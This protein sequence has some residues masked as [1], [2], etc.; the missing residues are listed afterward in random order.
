MIITVCAWCPDRKEREK[1]A[2]ESGHEVTHGI[3]PECFERV[4][5]E[6]LNT[7]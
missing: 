7:K 5:K 6:T 1:K 3:C 2:K 4:K